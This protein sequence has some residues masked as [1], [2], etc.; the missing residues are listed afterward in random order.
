MLKVRPA[1]ILPVL[2][3]LFPLEERGN[4]TGIVGHGQ[5]ENAVHES[6]V[7]GLRNGMSWSLVWHSH[8][9]NKVLLAQS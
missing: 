5:E 7:E 1:D 4:Q 9:I 2:L 3:R 8:M 6:S